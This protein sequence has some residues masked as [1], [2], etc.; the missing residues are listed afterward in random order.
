VT[1]F[2]RGYRDAIEH[3]GNNVASDH[4]ADYCEQTESAV[5]DVVRR[6]AA[7]A[8]SKKD[9]HYAKGDVAEAWHAGTFNVDAARRSVDAHA[10]APRGRSAIDVTMHGSKTQHAQ[11]KVYRSADDTTNAISD[12]KYDA[13]DQKIV[14]ADQ[15]DAVRDAAARRAATNAANRPQVAASAAHTAKVADDRVRLDEVE[16]RPLSER[17][18]RDLV[19]QLRERDEIDRERFALTPRQVI[20]WQDLLR[21]ATTAATR[22]AVISAALQAAPHLITIVRSAYET[23]EITASDLAPLA[24]TV[25][26]TLLRSGIAG[27]L[28]AVLLGSARMGILGSTAQQIDPTFVAAGVTLAMNALETSFRAARGEITWPIAAKS[29]SEDGIVLAAAMSGAA[30]GQALIPIPMLGALLGNIIGA[31]VARLVVEQ[32]NGVVLGLA[33]DTGWTVFGIVDQNHTVSAEILERSGWNILN[34]HKLELRPLELQG[35][36]LTPVKLEKLQ[37]HVLRRGVL[38]FGRIGY[39]P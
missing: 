16:S 8:S 32:A 18:A 2:R 15:L 38:S 19:K 12:S 14:P 35:F 1:D 31:V 11:L 26:T 5:D 6:M 28:S 3:F 27:G 39:L 10:V 22:A 9:I 30:I 23:G 4:L 36:Q 34:L 17:E 29:I 24:Q 13:I 21:E 33:A 20:Q 25:P 7:L 37:M